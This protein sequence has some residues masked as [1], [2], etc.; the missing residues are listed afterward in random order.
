MRSEVQIFPD[1][2]EFRGSPDPRDLCD[3]STRRRDDRTT[4]VVWTP[5]RRWRFQPLH[6]DAGAQNT[7]QSGAIAQLG[8]RL[9]CTQEVVGSIPS[10]STIFRGE[11][12]ENSKVQL[13]GDRFILLVPDA[14]EGQ[15]TTKS[16]PF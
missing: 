3:F 8:E 11:A 10:G 5:G 16:V 15:V 2:P 1:P 6:F 7:G 13:K 4:R 9:P 12:A 14:I